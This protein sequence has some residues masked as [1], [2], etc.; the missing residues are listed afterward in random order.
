M[1]RYL[2]Y[3]IGFVLLVVILLGVWYRF[4]IGIEVIDNDHYD[5][6]IGRGKWVLD[7]GILGMYAGSQ[8]SAHIKVTLTDEYEESWRCGRVDRTKPPLYCLKRDGDN[9]KI[10]VLDEVYEEV[11]EDKKILGINLMIYSS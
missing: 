3:V 6:Q 9:L 1:K 11:T 4:R 5:L 10:Y 2:S 8:Q 7:S